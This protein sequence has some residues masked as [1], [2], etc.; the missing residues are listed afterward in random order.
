MRAWLFVLIILVFP[1]QTVLA[2]G[3]ASESSESPPISDSEEWVLNRVKLNDALIE[4][5]PSSPIGSREFAKLVK[6][7]R[8][9]GF[10]LREERKDP[11]SVRTAVR[12]GINDFLNNPEIKPSEV[13][14]FFEDKKL[15]SLLGIGEQDADLQAVLDKEYYRPRNGLANSLLSP[16]FQKSVIGADQ[17]EKLL[18]LGGE[19]GGLADNGFDSRL[20]ALLADPRMD[21]A[22]LSQLHS[23]ADLIFSLGLTPVQVEHIRKA[24]EP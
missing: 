17:F 7:H 22:E 24:L 1:S 21:K 11:A 8:E 9:V 2:E 13:R 20:R 10:Y 12:N 23:N 19:S 15:R 18:G 4:H 16:L 5:F 14:K 6:I 3:H